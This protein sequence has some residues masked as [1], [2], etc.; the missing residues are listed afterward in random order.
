MLWPSGKRD[1]ATAAIRL[2][3]VK[4]KAGDARS[5]VA[6]ISQV[7]A[8]CVVPANSAVS[9]PSRIVT[10]KWAAAVLSSTSKR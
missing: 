6:P 2:V 3:A 9:A 10:A 4:R 5:P 8:N 1:I 7:T